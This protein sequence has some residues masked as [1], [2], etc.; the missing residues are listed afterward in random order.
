[1]GTYH[2]KEVLIVK[3]SVYLSLLPIYNLATFT[4]MAWVESSF[5]K[6]YRRILKFPFYIISDKNF[7]KS[8][9]FD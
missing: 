5:L 8:N 4:G 6:P 3:F 2:G 7:I 1:M 9:V